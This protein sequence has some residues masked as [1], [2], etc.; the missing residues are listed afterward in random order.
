M[1]LFSFATM[2]PAAGSSVVVAECSTIVFP[3][4]P[5]MPLAAD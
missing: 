1:R 4:G 2:S 5:L 3:E